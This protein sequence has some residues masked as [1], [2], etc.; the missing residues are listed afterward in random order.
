MSR[1]MHIQKWRGLNLIT[2]TLYLVD[3]MEI[4]IIKQMENFEDEGQSFYILNF[5]IHREHNGIPHP[6]AKK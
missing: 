3:I 5:L 6:K 1:K 2:I 4:E